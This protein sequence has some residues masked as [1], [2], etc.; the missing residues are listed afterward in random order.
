[1]Y[2]PSFVIGVLG[3]ISGESRHLEL[4]VETLTLSPAR[5]VT[6]QQAKDTS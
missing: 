3:S 5:S 4:P 1:M 2:Q 6:P